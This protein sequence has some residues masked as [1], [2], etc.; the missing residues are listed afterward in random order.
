MVSTRGSI[1]SGP[2]GGT[3]RIDV[4]ENEQMTTLPTTEET[5]PTPR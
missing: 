3:P 5:A 4:D 1:P 2:V